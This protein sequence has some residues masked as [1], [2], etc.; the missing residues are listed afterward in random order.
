MVG[1]MKKKK[2]FKPMFSFYN[3]NAPDGGLKDAIRDPFTYVML[4]IGVAAGF[5]AYWI[6]T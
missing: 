4:V 1:L 6:N 3:M 2:F 5:L